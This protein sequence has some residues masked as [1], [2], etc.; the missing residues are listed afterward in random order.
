MVKNLNALKLCNKGFFAL[1][2]LFNIAVANIIWENKCKGL[3][4]KK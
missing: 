1:S 4:F 3:T 2:K